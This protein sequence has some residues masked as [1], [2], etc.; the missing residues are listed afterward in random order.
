MNR[1]LLPGVCV[2]MLIAPP[3]GICA[4]QRSLGALQDFDAVHVEQ[5]Q[6]RADGAGEVDAV[7]VDA[8][9]GIRC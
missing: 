2:T 9:A 4:E 7:E 3:L 8:D 5:V 6:V 1:D